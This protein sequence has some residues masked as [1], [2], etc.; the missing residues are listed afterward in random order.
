MIVAVDRAD[1][2]VG[3]KALEQT[4]MEDVVVD[5]KVHCAAI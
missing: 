1:L 2:K 4:D 3:C 5:M